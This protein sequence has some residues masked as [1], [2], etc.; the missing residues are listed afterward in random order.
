MA[1]YLR[2]TIDEHTV[3]AIWKISE[4]VMELES[5]ITLREGEKQ[6]YDSFVAESRKKQWLAYRIL[7]RN[8]LKPGDYAVEY[9]HS[10]RPYLAGSGLH[11][12][13]THSDDMAAV[14]ISVKTKVGID[15]EKI[16]SRVGRVKERFLS[17]AEIGSI[18]KEKE[19]EQLTLAWS[20]KEALYKLYGRRDLDFRENI[21]LEIPRCTGQIFRAEIIFEEEKRS[22]EINNELIDGFILVYVT[23]PLP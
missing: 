23:D 19:Y 14:I 5:F 8:L 18:S 10:G 16:R 12:S 2:K 11:I 4:S 3:L 22:Y 6:L 17:P 15:I 7:I 13:V 1:E 21:R 9:D 20:A